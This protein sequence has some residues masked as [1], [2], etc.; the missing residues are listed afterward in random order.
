[1]GEVCA[2][3][4]S[5]KLKFHSNQRW[6]PKASADYI[7]SSAPKVYFLRDKRLRRVYRPRPLACGR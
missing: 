4:A 7:L 5:Q 3:L 2:F 6:I 1:M